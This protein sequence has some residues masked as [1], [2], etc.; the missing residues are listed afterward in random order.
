GVVQLLGGTITVDAHSLSLWLPCEFRTYDSEVEV[1]LKKRESAPPRGELRIRHA[2]AGLSGALPIQLC[3]E[4]ISAYFA[5]SP[6]RGPGV[7]I[8]YVGAPGLA[9]RLA[10]AIHHELPAARD[11]LLATVAREPNKARAAR[12]LAERQRRA[13]RD[14][15]YF[16]H[17]TFDFASSVPLSPPL[18]PASY[19]DVVCEGVSKNLLRRERKRA[20]AS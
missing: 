15:T 17:A 5:H 7:G 2:V 3:R 18:D 1:S 4:R 11:A 10:H 8:R 9:F 6:V 16:A 20:K 12:A 19:L 14:F 13:N